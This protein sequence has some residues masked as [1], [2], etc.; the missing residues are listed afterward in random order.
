MN[1]FNNITKFS[2]LR[3][4]LLQNPSVINPRRFF[5]VTPMTTNNSKDTV[6]IGCASGFWGDTPTAV[7]QLVNHGK[8]DFLVLDYLSEI[9][10]SLLVAAQRKSKDL[11]WCPDFAHSVGPLLGQIKRQ[12]IKVVS[13]A[14]GINSIACMQTMSSIAKK[15]GVDIKIAVVLGDDVFHLRDTVTKEHCPD[16]TSITS[17]NAYLGA[18]PIRRA[19]DLGADIVI[20]GRCT[21]SALALGP[22]VHSFDWAWDDFDL[23]SAGSL[24]GHLI[25]CGAQATGGICTEWESV[26]GW[27]N[28]GFPIAICDRS[29][30]SI[31]TK[32]DGTGG[33]VNR[34]TV[35]E[36]LLYEIH[37][38]T[39]YVLPDSVCD[40]S[41]V[42]IAE[43][44]NGVLV[45]GVRGLPPTDFYKIG[46]T[47]QD[48]WKC[49]T[50]SPVIGPK[51]AD[52]ALKTAEAIV[53]RCR[54]IYKHLKMA[55]FTS[56]YTHV[57][58]TEQAYGEYARKA[59]RDTR[60]AVSWISV[61]HQDRN[62]LE[63][64]AREVA[65]AGTG[66]APGL[67]TI[68]GGRPKPS[69]VLKFFSY[70]QPKHELQITIKTSDGHEEVLEPTKIPTSSLEDLKLKSSISSQVSDAEF[71]SYSY[72]LS[73][74]A[75]TRSGDKGDSCNIGVIAKDPSSYPLLLASLTED[76]VAKYFAHKS[77][78]GKSLICK[79]Y[80][81]PGVHG[82]NFVLE[83]SLGGGGIASLNCDPQGKAYGQML[84]DMQVE[85]A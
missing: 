10:M 52:K 43:Q 12:G 81:V 36:Q 57:L 53:A 63:I 67:T 2:R 3:K 85:K 77:S 20:C 13:N 69:P 21:D 54:G 76:K 16:P 26:P 61:Q 46:G 78:P 27:E 70:L 28:N 19:L 8:L 24:A 32:P 5:S 35:A 56:V 15:S 84:L 58:G 31:I 9:T 41:H 42:Q 6:R 73:E 34:C 83:N 14:G 82:L 11:G 51:A 60:E 75:W 71:P 23:I 74:L 37:D 49:T 72:K 1:N 33:L 80:E 64:F 66:M 68:V 7:S 40:L 17:M 48:G 50:V 18:A 29:G 47:Y 22:L 44:T 79:R 59:A 4:L 25:E 39:A 30:K 38:P 65:S 62:A 55:D 45:T